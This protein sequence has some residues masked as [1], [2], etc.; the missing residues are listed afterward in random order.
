MLKGA[1]CLLACFALLFAC[2]TKMPP[3]SLPSLPPYEPSPLLGLTG[4]SEEEGESME[5]SVVIPEVEKKDEIAEKKGSRDSPTEVEKT[6][7]AHVTPS[8]P[9][10]VLVTAERAAPLPDLT[11]TDLFFNPKKRLTVTLANVGEGPLPMEAGNLKIFVDGQLKGSYPLSSICDRPSL[12]PK[13]SIHFTPL[14]IMPRCSAAGLGFRIIPAGFNAP[15][16][17]SLWVERL[18][19]LT[20]LTTSL[21]FCGRPEVEAYV[22]TSEEV[23]EPDKENN[24]LKRVLGG[25]PIGSDIIIKEL[26]LTEDLE[27]SIILSN[28]G[29]V[30]LRRG[31]TFRIRV[32]VNDLKVSEFEH[33]TSE[34]L[35]AN[36][37]NQYSV[38]P[39]H[40]VVISGAAKVEVSVLPELPSDDVRLENNI[41]ERTFVIFPFR[42]V[43]QAS[44][45][46]SFY[47]PPLSHKV[48][49]EGERIKAEARWQ[50]GGDSLMLSFRGPEQFKGLPT[51]S[52]KSPLKVEVPIH[53]EDLR[54]ESLWRVSVVNLV[55]KRVE[56]YLIIQHP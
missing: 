17:E 27:L 20:G 56:G 23:R 21:S 53:F 33:F 35:K 52:G 15:P 30:D 44:Q 29:E 49:G 32:F 34:V 14:E 24:Y 36:S 25:H 31:V 51:L 1:I 46:F 4:L 16:V 48:D 3:P 42:L 26:D 47:I 11:I 45:E 7:V 5:E 39:P 43:P 12:Q 40:R 54:K 28:A 18:E 37:G 22:E 50:G 13:D 2:A 6:E 10:A 8:I 41:L 55:E 9:I 19:F 38:A